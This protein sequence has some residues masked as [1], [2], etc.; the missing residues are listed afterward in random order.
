MGFM[1]SCSIVFLL[2]MACGTNTSGDG[3][4]DPGADAGVPGTCS[5]AADCSSDV[6]L[7]NPD[8]VCVQ[9]VSSA[10]C[11][12]DAPI[13]GNGSCEAA[14]AGD[15]VSANF[16][17]VPSDIIWVVDQSGSMDQETDHVQEQINN[18]VALIDQSNIDYRVV[19]I[20]STGGSNSIC[21]PSPLGG[22]NC[23]NN[24]QFRLVNQRIGSHDA[25]SQ[26]ISRY[27]LYS[28]FLRPEA[29]KHFVYVTDDNANTSAANFTNSLEALQPAGM[30]ANR[31]IHGIYAFGNGTTG[32]TG[33]FGTGAAEGTVYTTLISQTAGASGVI[34][35]DDWTQVFDDITQAVISGSQV[36]CSIAVP[37]APDGQTLDPNLVNVNYLMS[38]QPPGE[39]LPRVQTAGDCGSAGGW[40]YDDN[41][42][43][44]SIT[45]CPDSCTAI[46]QDPGASVKLELGC[47]AD[48]F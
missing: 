16:V 32:C 28:D 11:S 13:C 23:G 47:A 20:A 46:Q 21:V 34:C 12:A 5:S 2:V 48:L 15:Q 35:D 26:T 14:C 33:T 42:A 40:Y 3:D 19:M 25:L 8:G 24:T 36:S 22:A 29:I 38:G 6:P 10:D 9:C 4:D 31:K 39:T 44:T 1:R 17:T 7:C 37:A 45:L 30:F 18:F 27:S 41:A 43:P